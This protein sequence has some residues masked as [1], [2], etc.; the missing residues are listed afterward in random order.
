VRG[1]NCMGAGPSKE[2][3]SLIGCHDMLYPDDSASHCYK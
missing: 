2:T 3:G 1:L